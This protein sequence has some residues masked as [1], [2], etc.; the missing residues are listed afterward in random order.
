MKAYTLS[1]FLDKIEGA[2]SGQRGDPH[3]LRGDRCG[4][5]GLQQRT[6]RACRNAPGNSP[7][8]AFSASPGPKSRTILFSQFA[9]EIALRLFPLGLA[10]V[11]GSSSTLIAH[12]HSNEIFQIP[13]VVGARSYVIAA[14]I[15]VAAAAASAWMVSRRVDRLDLVAVLKTRE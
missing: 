10:A 6:H 4:R 11:A 14:I 12:F 2:R 8:C 7:A 3:G 13:G 5:R 15:V 9:I 1:S